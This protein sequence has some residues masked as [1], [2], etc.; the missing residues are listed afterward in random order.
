MK[1]FKQ[2][3]REAQVVSAFP[4]SRADMPQLDDIEKFLNWCYETKDIKSVLVD[5]PVEFVKPTQAEYDEDKVARMGVPDSPILISRDF[6]I[7]DGHH[8][9]FAVTLNSTKWDIQTHQIDVTINRALA[10]AKEYIE[11]VQDGS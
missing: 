4:I 6:F 10:L 9:F 11:T 3:L 8:R 7:V 5:T 2:F 1:T